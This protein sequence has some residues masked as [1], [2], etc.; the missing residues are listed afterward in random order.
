MFGKPKEKYVVLQEHI[1]LR[2]QR[3]LERAVV[4]VLPPVEP[5]R[6]FVN[7]LAYDLVEEARHRETERQHLH[8]ATRIFGVMGGGLLSIIGGL[9]IWLLVRNHGN[10]AP[11]SAASLS[12]R[13]VASPSSA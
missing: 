7:Q 3:A 12:G 2:E 9:I 8:Q 6:S 4:T 5:S 13:P 10:I 1:P 11:D